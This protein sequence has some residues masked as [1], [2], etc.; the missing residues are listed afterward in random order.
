M[1]VG[2]ERAALRREAPVRKLLLLLAILVVLLPGAAVAVPVTLED[3]SAVVTIDPDSPNG[4]S[5][6]TVN[7]VSHVSYQWFWLRAGG[8]LAETSIDALDR[9]AAVLSDVDD[10]GDD[11]T[12]FVSF[13][14]PSDRFAL[15]LRWSLAGSPFA[16]PTSAI[17]SDI[18]V[19]V[20]LTN[21]TPADLDVTLFEYT[22]VDLFG[23]AVDDAA[24]FSGTPP[25][26]LE[27]T[28]SSGL[29]RYESV[30]S[31]PPSAVEAAL[32]DRTLASLT[33]GMLTVLS[34]ARSAE[35]DVTGTVAWDLRLEPAASFLLSQDQVIRVAAIPE[36]SVALLLAAG[37]AG[38]GAARRGQGGST[39]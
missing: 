15:E 16:P 13:A 27:V 22:D 4:L 10:D 28:D 18:A 6:W 34:G 26:T 1:P 19:Q 23:S 29:V 20:S 12:F 39:R 7:G 5:A 36:P 37:L 25:N 14:D 9:T 32:F 24:L 21:L 2:T 11:D 31:S 30:S 33:D 8:E 3:G 17:A 38:L 35:G